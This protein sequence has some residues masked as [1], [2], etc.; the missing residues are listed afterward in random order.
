[1]QVTRDKENMRTLLYVPI[2]HTEA[3]LGSVGGD[4]AKRGRREFGETLWKR[5]Q[6]TVLG[7]WDAIAG[8]FDSIDASD[9]KIFQDGMVADG[10]TGIAIV[11][12]VVKTG[13][14]N[15][16][17]ISE[18]MRKGAILVMTEDFNLVREERNWI[19]KITQA[20]NRVQKLDAAMKYKLV[21][22]NLLDKRDKFIAKQINNMLQEGERGILFIGAFHNV[23]KWLQKDIVVEEIKDINRVKEYQKLLPFY[24]SN[25]ERVEKLRIYLTDKRERLKRKGKAVE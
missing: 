7:F 15:Y 18:L 14:K 12:E 24:R 20:K 1:M 11:R 10:E 17:I 19:L 16:Q 25:K 21:K 23:R 4:M 3:D 8:Y 2:I 9:F 5:H 6:E 22:D 13:S